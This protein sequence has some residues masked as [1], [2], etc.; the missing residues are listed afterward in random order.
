MTVIWSFCKTG[1]PLLV[2]G[3][4]AILCDFDFIVVKLDYQVFTGY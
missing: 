4:H 3:M 2:F 1:R